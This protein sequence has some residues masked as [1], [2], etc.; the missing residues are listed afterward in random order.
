MLQQN[1]ILSSFLTNCSVALYIYRFLKVIVEVL[2]GFFFRESDN[3][4]RA[5]EF[6]DLLA[7]QGKQVLKFMSV[8]DT[9]H[10]ADTF[11]TDLTDA[12]WPEV[13]IKS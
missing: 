9:V 8:P 13:T 12:Q 7:R 5:S 2:M 11:I 6:Q 10:K 3:S 4:I 1:F